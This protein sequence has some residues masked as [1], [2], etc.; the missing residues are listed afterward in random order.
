M[1][2]PPAFEMTLAD[3][4]PWRGAQVLVWALAGAGL[5]AWVLTPALGLAA[6][7]P[8]L[9]AAAGACSAAAGW[10]V[11]RGWR[12]VLRWTGHAWEVGACTAVTP[13]AQP[14]HPPAP[15]RAAH[16]RAMLDVNGFVLL[17]VRPLDARRA[18]WVGLCT[19]DAGPSGHLLRAAVYC[20]PSVDRGRADEDS[21]R[22]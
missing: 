15:W 18:R 13:S 8:W 6:Q 14:P 1:R 11:S 22:S 5:A 20:A 3:A 17:R 7:A 4:P 12:G 9:V 10:R 19:A 2:A 21:A 16:V